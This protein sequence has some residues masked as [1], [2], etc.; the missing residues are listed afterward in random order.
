[1]NRAY[2]VIDIDD[3]VNPPREIFASQDICKVRGYGFSYAQENDCIVVVTLA[4]GVVDACYKKNDTE[5]E[6]I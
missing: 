6:W 3:I 1:M 2:V 5:G 4:N